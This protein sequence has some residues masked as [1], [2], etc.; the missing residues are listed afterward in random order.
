MEGSGYRN[1]S[2]SHS[3]HDS[4][5]DNGSGFNH[6]PH[7]SNNR[8]GR[9]NGFPSFGPSVLFG[10]LG[11]ALGIWWGGQRSR[12]ND[13]RQVPRNPTIPGQPS[14]HPVPPFSSFPS[15]QYPTYPHSS[16]SPLRNH[17]QNVPF[18]PDPIFYTDPP[19]PIRKKTRNLSSCLCFLLLIAIILA[20]ILVPKPGVSDVTIVA[21]DRK[22]VPVKAQWF[23]EVQLSGSTDVDVFYFQDVPP[24]NNSIRLTKSVNIKLERDSFHYVRYDLQAASKIKTTWSLTRQTS[25][26]IVDSLYPPDE[27]SDLPSV[28]QDTTPTFA[29]LKSEAAFLAWKA[30]EYVSKSYWLHKENI[31]TGSYNFTAAELD[32]YYFLFFGTARHDSYSGTAHF[33]GDAITYSLDNPAGHCDPT[34]QVLCTIQLSP[35]H[36]A[37]L[38][39]AAP[40]HGDSYSVRVQTV[41]RKEA[42]AALFASLSSGVTLTLV[43]ALLAWFGRRCLCPKPAVA[44]PD[45]EDVEQYEYIP[46]DV[47]PPRIDASYQA[48]TS[49]SQGAPV[50]PYNPAFRPSPSR[51]G[52]SNATPSAPPPYSITDPNADQPV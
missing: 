42:Y 27:T 11:G 45:E 18:L 49:L 47:P 52:D 41:R 24:L 20:A 6:G 12:S 17:T 21:G 14:Y 28:V 34:S 30:N 36:P 29:I 7:W 1:S 15:D 3:H 35:D 23:S 32:S 22:L 8:G 4:S 26:S 19:M 38:V 33:V 9:N 48:P 13:R 25:K 5:N 46:Y 16:S 2:A 10:A 43:V 37:F 40:Q 31:P 51:P 44:L 50:D 39:L